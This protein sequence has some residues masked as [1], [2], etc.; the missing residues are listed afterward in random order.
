MTSREQIIPTK[1]TVQ[2]LK[3]RKQAA[4]RGHALLKK[5]VDALNS[6]YRRLQR[7]MKDEKLKMID[8]LKESY[9]QLAVAQKSVSGDLTTLLQQTVTKIPSSYVISSVE[10]IAGVRL[11]SLALAKD[12]DA[13]EVTS[14]L[15]GGAMVLRKSAEKWNKCLEQMVK[16]A[17]I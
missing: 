6:H 9:W 5:K 13:A 15:G 14:S 16:V 2:L 11:P 7:E 3:A 4:V 8:I 17:S 1:A 12:Q 10:N